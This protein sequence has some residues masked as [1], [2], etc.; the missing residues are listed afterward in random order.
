MTGDNRT[1]WISM[2]ARKIT[3][4]HLV[5][6]QDFR[7]NCLLPGHAAGIGDRTRRYRLFRRRAA[8]GSFEHD[9]ARIVF[10]AGPLQQGSQW[11]TRPFCVADGAQLPLRSSNL[12]DEKDPTIT[13]AL[14]SS[15]PRLGGHLPQFLV[16]QRQRVPDRAIDPEL[17]TGDVDPW[18]REVTAY[19]EQLRRGE[20]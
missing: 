11:H 15:G 14:Q 19:V 18:R 7:L 12:G 13:R 8:I 1:D 5:S 17:I 2:V 10:Q 3:P 4:I 6:D 16:A 20:V 9:F